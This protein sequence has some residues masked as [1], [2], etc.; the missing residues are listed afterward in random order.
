MSEAA[1]RVAVLDLPLAAVLEPDVVGD[2]VDLLSVCLADESREDSADDRLHTGGDDDKRDVVRLTKGVELLEAWVEL[3]IW[4]SLLVW[5]Q[6]LRTKRKLT[7]L[8]FLNTILERVSLCDTVKHELERVAEGGAT[9]KD[10][11]ISL[12]PELCPETELV[13]HVC[14]SMSTRKSDLISKCWHG[15]GL[16]SLT[17]IAVAGGDGPVPV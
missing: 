11:E 12:S 17:V 1:R 9:L 13:G 5:I 4:G 16:P 15:K 2:D 3:D 10:V 7:F 14:T 8:E 6:L